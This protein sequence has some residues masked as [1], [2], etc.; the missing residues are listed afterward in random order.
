MNMRQ[1]INLFSNSEGLKKPGFCI[2][3]AM[4]AISLLVMNCSSNRQYTELQQAFANPPEE[5]RPWVYWFWN[6]DIDSTQIRFQLEEMKRSHTVSTVV[7]LAWEGLTIEFLS[8]EWFDQVKYACDIAAEVG[9]K[10]CL[11]DEWCWPSG[12]AGGIMLKNHPEL[13][14]KC[15][16]ENRQS[17]TGPDR[18]TTTVNEESASIF[19]VPIVNGQSVYTKLTNLS[20][21]I[22]YHSLD[23]Q[24]PEGEWEILSYEVKAGDFRPVFS[25]MYYVDLLDPRTAAEFIKINHARYYAKMPEYFGN[26]ITSIITDEPG[27]YQNLKPWGINP[28]T[29]AWTPGFSDEFRKRKQ[30]DLAD[31]LPALWHNLGAESIKVRNDYYQVVA[32]LLQDSY[33]KPLHDWAEDHQ[34]QLNIQP[35][36]EEELKYSAIM[37]G[38]YF[39][40]MEYSHIQGAD[41]VYH[42]N[43]KAITPKIASSAARSFGTHDLFCEVFGA[44]GWS[45]T[46]EK[47]KAVTDWLFARGVNHLM[48]S[49]FYFE[50]QRNWRME[51]APSLFIGTNYWP[52]LKTYTDYTSRLSFLLSGGQH[53][54]K[55]AVL[56]PDKSARFLLNPI[57]E[58]AV[59]TLDSNFQKLCEQLL[60]WQ[61]DYDIVN[62]VTLQQKMRISTENGK[63]VLNLNHRVVQ[64]DYELMILP[65]VTVVDQATLDVI[66]EF[67]LTGGTVIAI[68]NLPIW[69]T[70]G[71]FVFEDT[72][73]IWNSEWAG[74]PDKSGKAFQIT[75]LSCELNH[76]LQLNLKQDIRLN[77]ETAAVNF[78]HKRKAGL[79]IYFVTNND[80]LPVTNEISFRN[81]GVPEIWNPENGQIRTLVAYRREKGYTIMPLKLDRYGSQCVVFHRGPGPNIHPITGDWQIENISVSQKKVVTTAAPLAAGRSDLTLDID[82]KYAFQW[83]NVIVDTVYLE[84]QWLFSAS[85][86]SIRPAIRSAGSWTEDYPGFSGIGTY[87]QTFRMDSAWFTN[88]NRFFIHIGNVGHSVEIRL[89]E[90]YVTQRCWPPYN[91]AITGCLIPGDN[92]LKLRI[93]NSMA[94]EREKA[95]Y[96]SGL[97]SNVFITVHPVCEFHW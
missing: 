38:D 7:L 95:N 48:L 16:S 91:A 17:I 55:I 35:A 23:W 21:Q 26:V 49:S 9:L 70:A 32:E 10:I 89:N 61:W 65:Y 8:D 39:S 58:T 6:G 4:F 18:F 82:G 80:S 14:S 20:N 68:G 3:T 47:M 77:K 63:A 75:G 43:P 85:D 15:L 64:S 44:Y 1:F 71:K 78:I 97:L 46:I 81:T 62:D 54:A 67:Y 76:L 51:I 42:W 69:N 29:I 87:T 13:R 52:F 37:Q 56:Y 19:A 36:H 94:N 34:I 27:V 84:N 83:Q 96:P 93:A 5:Y 88:D 41:A 57:D 12:H 53:V 31:Y 79:D 72:E 11:Y 74:D 66:R 30:Y 40:A 24:V 92:L 90:Q 25:E 28:E 73:V 50:N 59:S 33:F 60:A 2:F 86:S 45:T 22:S